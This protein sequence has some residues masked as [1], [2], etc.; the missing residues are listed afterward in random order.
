VKLLT[1]EKR[2]LEIQQQQARMR[3]PLTR[4]IGVGD[5]GIDEPDIMTKQRPV[6][7]SNS[8]C[9]CCCCCGSST[10]RIPFVKTLY[11]MLCGICVKLALQK[12]PVH[13]ID[14]V[15]P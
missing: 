10:R 12:K 6:S 2:I 5:A 3:T 14:I 4:S 13:D 1:D 15:C 8:C 7:S 9:C 11:S